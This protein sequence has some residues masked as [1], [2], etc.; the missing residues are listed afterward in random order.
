LTWAWV[1]AGCSTP[2]DKPGGAPPAAAGAPAAGAPAAAPSAAAAGW[3]DPRAACAYLDE[4]GYRN[5]G[6]KVYDRSRPSDFTCQSLNR[7]VGGGTAV[8]GEAG[9]YYSVLGGPDRA[10]H[11]RLRVDVVRGGADERPALDEFAATAAELA[12]RAFAANLPDDAA[13]A[14]REGK[15]GTWPL[16]GGHELKVERLKEKGGP[17]AQVY[18]VIAE[19]RLRRPAPGPPPRKRGVRSARERAARGRSCG[20]KCA[21]NI[22]GGG[23]V[24]YRR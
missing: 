13:A 14:L 24:P 23:A 11:L 18:N 17:F 21:K 16:G 7:K 19:M 22:L 6:Y 5:H 2:A 15:S 8:V 10:D 12:R 9:F 4:R 1:C 3:P 20:L